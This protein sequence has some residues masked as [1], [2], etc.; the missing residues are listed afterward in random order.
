METSP[1]PFDGYPPDYVTHNL[2]LVVLSGLV[3][4]QPLV[5]D[6]EL[7]SVFKGKGTEITSE[8]PAVEGERA[9]QLLQEF[10]HCTKTDDQWNGKPVQGRSGLSGFRFRAV[11]RVGQRMR[12]SALWS[13]C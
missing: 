12:C 8:L 6:T 9:E 13:L 4:A 10:Y 5:Q 1:G 11:G 2:P 7:P 3:P